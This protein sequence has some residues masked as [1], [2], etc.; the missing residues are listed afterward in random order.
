MIEKVKIISL[1]GHIQSGKSEIAKIMSKQFGYTSCSL[2]GLTKS[3]VSQVYGVSLEELEDRKY[4]EKWRPL[5]IQYAEKI[6]EVDL[7]AHCKYVLGF[8]K[9]S[10]ETTSSRRYLISDLRYPYEFLYFKKL[11]R[12]SQH[13]CE[14]EYEGLK[15]YQV[16]YKS[17]FID[18]D[19]ADKSSLALS[20]S[21]YESYLKPNSDGLILNGVEQRYSRGNDLINQ[22]V[23]FV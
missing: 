3:I 15:N 4:K 1:S 21:Y 6:K 19:L 14:T 7:Y 18:S 13:S 20:E 5:I 11:D 2:A 23:K 16:E 9:K 22:L 8:I 12:C 10:L 17:L